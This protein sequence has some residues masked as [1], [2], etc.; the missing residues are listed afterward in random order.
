MPVSVMQVGVVGVFVA[1]WWVRVAVGVGFAL[2]VCGG[3][4]VLM[5]RVVHVG[6]FVG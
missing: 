2:G 5:V 1:E 6:V 4:G 3:V